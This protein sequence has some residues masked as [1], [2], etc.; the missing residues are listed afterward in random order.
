MSTRE[1]DDLSH[2]FAGAGGG[3]LSMT[4]TYPL[5]TL[6]THAQTMVK[7]KKDQ[8]KEKEN[9][10]EDGSLSPKSSNTSD[11]SQKKISQFEILKKILKDQGAKGLYNGL[12][13]ALFGIAVTNFVY[14][15]FYEL[16]GKTLNRRS[17]PQTA[18]NSKKV[19]LKKGLSVWQSMAAGAVAGTISR[20]ATN[21]IWVANTRM[22]ILSKNQGK[23]GKL[24]T[25]EA[26]IYILKNEG[27][28][29]LFTG[30][31][32]ALFLV[33]NP[34][35]QYTI[36]EQLKSFI[37]KIKKRNITPVDALLLGAFGKL[38]ATIITYPYITLR[39]RMHVKSMTEISEDVEKER[40]DSVQSLPEDG[41]DEDNLKENSAKS[42]YAETITK[43]ISKLPSPIVS[44]FTLG[45]GMYKEE[46]VSS[47]YRGLSVKL[48]QSILNAA[49]LFYFKEELLIL[50]DGIIKSTK[51]ATGLANNPYNAKDVIHS[52]EKA[53]SM[54]SPRTRT[55]TV[56]S[57]AKE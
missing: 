29:K 51:R 50:S 16:T 10:N 22:T 56:A 17:N 49:F 3:L 34:I 44:M 12:E 19:A 52:F 35:I 28:Q 37:V 40:T 48:L 18:S 45:Y 42:P 9:S 14:Y 53:L 25:I 5:V 1:Y 23:L 36:F 30:I 46:G 26:I 20:V 24:N 38:I 31:V 39:S 21:P 4:L 15:Y 2:A 54:R 7:L 47:F 55:T 11:V 6:T 27:W 33:L 32:P 41:S 8:E 13:S 57:S 43:I